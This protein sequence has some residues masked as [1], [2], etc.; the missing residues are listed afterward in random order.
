MANIGIGQLRED[1]WVE[2]PLIT[3]GTDLTII[4]T[5][6]AGRTHYSANDVIDYLLSKCGPESSGVVQ[7]SVPEEEAARRE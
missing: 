5:F 4:S 3:S 1:G 7:L 6:L 2:P